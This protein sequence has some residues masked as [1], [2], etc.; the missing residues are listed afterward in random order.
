[1][2][3]LGFSIGDYFFWIVVIVSLIMSAKFSDDGFSFYPPLI[4]CSIIIIPMLLYYQIDYGKYISSDL[5]IN[6]LKVGVGTEEAK[7]YTVTIDKEN[8]IIHYSDYNTKTYK[9][10]ES[11]EWH[12]D[13]YVKEY[14]EVTN[15]DEKEFISITRM[16]NV[17]LFNTDRKQ[18]KKIKINY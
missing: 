8:F 9:L 1:M 4:L 14:V 13:I 7:E 6:G 12:G 18:L 15:A 16:G 2:E 3:E 11:K 5:E 10:K 17:T